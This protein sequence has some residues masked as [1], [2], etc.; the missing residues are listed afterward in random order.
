MRTI[1]GG[2]TTGGG[3]IGV[4]G[5]GGGGP[6]QGGELSS[7]PPRFV[8]A[9]RTSTSTSPRF[10]SPR[11]SAFATP[12]LMPISATMPGKAITPRTQRAPA[13]TSRCA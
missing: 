5:G 6:F 3:V 12:T 8:P 9:R 1:G 4:S 7:R 13:T 11:A 10:A 2:D